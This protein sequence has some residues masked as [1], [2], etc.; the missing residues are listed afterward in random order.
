MKDMEINK[1]A[2]DSLYM[3]QS[4]YDKDAIRLSMLKKQVN[5][6]HEEQGK[7]LNTMIKFFFMKYEKE[8]SFKKDQ[9]EVTVCFSFSDGTE[10]SIVSNSN[11][12]YTISGIESY[13]EENSITDTAANVTPIVVTLEPTT[14]KSFL[15]KLSTEEPKILFIE[16]TFRN[17]VDRVM[18]DDFDE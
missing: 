15:R 10:I 8:F 2:T 7:I 13:Q 14:V 5:E 12:P 16:R 4:L 17:Y 18:G 1:S 6:I 9:I 11:T 3:L